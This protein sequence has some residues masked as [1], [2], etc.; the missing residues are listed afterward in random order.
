MKGDN[1]YLIYNKAHFYF[2]FAQEGA[3]GASYI[4]TSLKA[5]T[6]INA[7][8]SIW[9]CFLLFSP[10]GTFHDVTHSGNYFVQSKKTNSNQGSATTHIILQYTSI[11]VLSSFPFV[12]FQFV[13]KSNDKLRADCVSIITLFI[14][15]HFIFLFGRC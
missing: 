10:E 3:K 4:I 7:V 6:Q 13:F 5:T 12:L 9:V 15:H 8:I 1:K 14:S 11:F 2:V